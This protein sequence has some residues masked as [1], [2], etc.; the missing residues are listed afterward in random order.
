MKMTAMSGPVVVRGAP[1]TRR[2]PRLAGTGALLTGSLTPR[3]LAPRGTAVF[4]RSPR[5]S[6][7][8]YALPTPLVCTR[9]CAISLL[10]VRNSW[11]STFK[12]NGA[13][14]ERLI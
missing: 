11:N 13:L 10:S 8:R 1:P 14:A 12:N 3:R 2:E 5:A 9:V 4:A 7:L 6:P